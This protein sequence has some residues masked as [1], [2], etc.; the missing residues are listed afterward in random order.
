LV[1]GRLG[2]DELWR[3]SW[4]QIDERRLGCEEEKEEGRK[5]W[6]QSGEVRF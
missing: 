2:D 6:A 4:A 5:Y 1:L 3:L